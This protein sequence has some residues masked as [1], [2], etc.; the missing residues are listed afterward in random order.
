M[1]L[2]YGTILNILIE[3]FI[4]HT[5]YT[6]QFMSKIILTVSR[7]DHCNYGHKYALFGCTLI[8]NMT[9]KSEQLGNAQMSHRNL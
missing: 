3:K 8:P 1:M 6:F 4:L 9:S 5:Q 2:K 7:S